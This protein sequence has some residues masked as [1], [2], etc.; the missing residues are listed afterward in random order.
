MNEISPVYNLDLFNNGKQENGRYTPTQRYF[1]VMLLDTDKRE[2]AGVETPRY[3]YYSEIL[4]IPLTTLKN[5]YADKEHIAK[6]SSA[7]AKSVIQT[8]QMQIAMSLPKIYNKLLEGI[9]DENVKYADKINLFREAINKMRLL[10]NNSTENV[11]HNHIHFQPI[12][13]KSLE[14]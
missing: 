13:P 14:K 5:W 10:S 9:D 2:R 12:V 4:N 11:Q 7:I 6:E 8:T 3:T 1:A